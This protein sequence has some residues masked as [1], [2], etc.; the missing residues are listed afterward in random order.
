MPRPYAS[1]APARHNGRV[2]A[3]HYRFDH[4][5]HVDAGADAVLAL[6][7]DV[8]GYARWWPSVRVVDGPEASGAREARLVVRAPVGY[9]IR[10]ALREVERAPGE[11]RA[12]ISGDLAGWCAW[13]VTPE[14]AG[15]RVDFAQEV[16]AVAP[17]L[18]AASPALHRAFAEQ[19]A[20]VMRR[21]ELGMRAALGR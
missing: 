16:E 14:G 12:A 3:A 9:R 10:I 1:G 7:E 13:R 17:L 15:A 8:R 21:A 2:R 20:S 4:S 11:L 6:L 5:W 19:H 18:R